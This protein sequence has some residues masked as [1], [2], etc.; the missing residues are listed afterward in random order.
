VWGVWMGRQIA[1]RYGDAL[2]TCAKLD[3]E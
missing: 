2:D 1:V 3:E